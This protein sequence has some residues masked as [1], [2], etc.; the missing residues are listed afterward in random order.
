MV[1]PPPE[2]A[3]APDRGVLDGTGSKARASGN[4]VPALHATGLKKF[5][6]NSLPDDVWQRLCK[7]AVT[8]DKNLEFGTRLSWD[9]YAAAQKYLEDLNK[10]PQARAASKVAKLGEKIYESRLFYFWPGELREAVSRDGNC[11]R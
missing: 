1:D 10:T 2:I 11:G 8:S 6:D 4:K 9:R 5:L 7:T 3:D